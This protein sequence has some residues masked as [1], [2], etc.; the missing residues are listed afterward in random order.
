MTT[1]WAHAAHGEWA[2]AFTTQPGGLALCILAAAVFWVAL[3]TAVFGSRALDLALNLL[4]PKPLLLLAALLLGA[5]VYKLATWP[6]EAGG[7]AV[8]TPAVGALF[9]R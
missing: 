8:V 2:A 7:T 6:A 1:S 9:G 3:H 5:W 4:Q